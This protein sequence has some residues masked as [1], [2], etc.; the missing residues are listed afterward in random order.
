MYNPT[1]GQTDR[2][3]NITADGTRINPNKASSYRYI[4]LSRNLL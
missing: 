2:T 4:A 3:P 1:P